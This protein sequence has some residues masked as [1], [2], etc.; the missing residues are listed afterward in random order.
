MTKAGLRAIRL[1]EPDARAGADAPRCLLVAIGDA[2]AREVVGRELYDDLVAG[3]D[4]DIVHA[5]LARDGAEHRMTVTQIDT[6]HRVGQ[7]LG[8]RT[9]ELDCVFLLHKHIFLSNDDSSDL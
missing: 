3:K 5:D 8:D 2:P 4:A 7:R 9:L 6:K 1:S